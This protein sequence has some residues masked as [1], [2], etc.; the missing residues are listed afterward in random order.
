MRLT[1]LGTG[2][3]QGVPVIACQCRV[4][5]SADVRDQRLRASVLFEVAGK[6]FVVDTGPDFRQQMLRQRVM[7]LDAVLFTHRHKDHIAGL[8]D[9]RSF[10]FKQQ[11]KMPVYADEA[12]YRQL[13]REFA[14]IFD[15]TNYPG[16]PQLEVY[17]ITDEPFVVDG[18]DVTPIPVL[19]YKMPVLGFRIGNTAY[20][21]DASYIPPT[22]MEL[23]Q[24]LDLLVLNA[25]RK[26]THISHF[27]L[28]QALA[29]VD[30]LRP[31]RAYFTHISH[32]MGLH[33]D[34]Q[35]ELPPHVHIAHDGLTVECE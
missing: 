6:T 12:T 27:N 28:E 26:E 4:C 9:V 23:L 20:I 3:S 33:A 1:F 15:G 25:L 10:N 30:Q 14:Y 21:T 2:T 31:R 18:V 7:H 17:T 22:S 16:I 32:L 13:T 11:A 34:V 35:P 8:D 24:G 29:I 5:T 19:H